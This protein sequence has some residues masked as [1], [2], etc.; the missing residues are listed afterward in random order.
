VSLTLGNKG[1]ILVTIQIGSFKMADILHDTL[2][3]IIVALLTLVASWQ[4]RFIKSLFDAE[5]RRQSKQ[6]IGKWNVIETF[7]DGTEDNF[8]MELNCRG[9]KV[10]GTH[11]CNSGF[12]EGKEYDINGMYK[13][14]ILSFKWMPKDSEMLESGTVT[15]LLLPNNKLLD[16]HGLY[17]EPDDGKVYTST[18]KASK[19]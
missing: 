2:I 7:N 18:F 12:D 14:H 15:V 16:G 3:T 4:W 6:I 19:K 5:I 13:D 17:I 10:T 9:G 11:Y 8:T 1:R